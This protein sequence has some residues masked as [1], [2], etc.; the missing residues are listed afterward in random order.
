VRNR[1][2][3]VEHASRAEEERVGCSRNGEDEGGEQEDQAVH[4]AQT[5]IANEAR[6]S[7]AAPDVAYDQLSTMSL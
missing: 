1:I 6:Q 2:H 7:G 4:G 5:V 3:A